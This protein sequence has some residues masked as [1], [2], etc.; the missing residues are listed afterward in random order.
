MKR[1]LSLITA[2]LLSLTLLFGQVFVSADTAA[3]APKISVSSVEKHSGE[4]VDVTVYVSNNPGIVSM[5]LNVNFDAEDL[6]L[7]KVTDG[8][9]LGDSVHSNKYKSPYTLSWSNDLS[10]SNITANGLAVTLTFKISDRISEEK[11][12]PITVTYNNDNYDI[13]DKNMKPVEFAIENGAVKA[14]PAVISATGVALNKD[15]LTLT[16]GSS[17]TLTAAVQPDNAANKTVIWECDNPSV[18][19]VDSNGKVTAVNKGTA[20]VSATTEDGG[21]TASCKVTVNCAHSGGTHLVG[22]KDATTDS[23]GYTGDT[24]CDS[25]GEIIAYG[26][27][28]DPP[29]LVNENNAWYYVENGKKCNKTTLV[30]YYGT[31]YYVKDGILDR[32]AN[33]LFKYYDTW[34]YIKNG[35]VDFSAT[36]LC[37]YYNTWYYV[38]N[39][40]KSN[41]TTLVKYYDTWYYVEKGKVNWNAT[42]LCKYG[43]TWYYVEKGK[44]NFKANLSFKYYGKY[45]NV[46]NGVVRF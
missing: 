23:K 27:Y 16:A 21:F 25:C 9:I 35:Q 20:T 1:K 42:T 18:A 41:K 15:E 30:K 6:E 33:T 37:K 5:L 8:G 24:V 26:T 19:T 14:I 39:G 11:N 28:I 10:T 29:T 46:R 12:I 4:T 17:E 7:T 2:V 31:W 40:K 32:N 36:T 43:N 44:V 13:I 3:E 34:Y 45:Y 38:E 22:Q